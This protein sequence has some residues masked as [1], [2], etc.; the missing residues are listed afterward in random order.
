MVIN[1][2][3]FMS[4]DIV[5]ITSK[6]NNPPKVMSKNC[7]YYPQSTTLLKEVTLP[8]WTLQRLFTS[9]DS[10]TDKIEQLGTGY[11]YSGMCVWKLGRSS[12]PAVAAYLVKGRENP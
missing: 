12:A 8:L 4:K 1:F 3:K 5:P 11:N 7:G 6:S 2:I 10:G 9:C